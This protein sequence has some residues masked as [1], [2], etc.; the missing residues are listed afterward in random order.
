MVVIDYIE[1]L[2]SELDVQNGRIT[3]WA[4]EGIYH[5]NVSYIDGIPIKWEGHH[6]SI[7]YYTSKDL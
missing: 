1:V 2:V 5:M 7:L 3:F 4:P 6:Q